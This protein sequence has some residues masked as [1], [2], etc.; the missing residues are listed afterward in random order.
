MKNGLLLVVCFAV[1]LSGCGDRKEVEELK[2]E[3]RSLR[4]SLRKVQDQVNRAQEIDRRLG[5]LTSRLRGIKARLVTNL[6]DIEL[7]FY[8]ER[9]PIHCFNF[10]ARA[11]SGFYDNT[12]FHRV[13]PRFMIQGGD[14]NSKD[15]DPY[16]DG[17]G[18]PICAIPHEFNDLSHRRGVLSMA[19]APEKSAGAGSQ[20]FI[21]HADSPHLDREYTAFG[22]VTKGMDVVDRIAT[23]ATHT[24]DPRLANRP[25]ESVVIQAI[26]VYR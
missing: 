4:S 12:Q 7:K 25:I 15:R 14:P 10:I 22:E 13:I 23:A 20:F 11:E 8:P 19:R 24:D 1:F 3:N 5:F 6:G 18:D 26:R 9:A 2:G 17:Q 16:N 21:V